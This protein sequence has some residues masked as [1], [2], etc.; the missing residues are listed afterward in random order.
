M[1]ISFLQDCIHYDSAPGLIK[2]ITV[3]HDAQGNFEGATTYFI[4]RVSVRN[5]EDITSADRQGDGA[6]QDGA[7]QDAASQQ[8][9][10]NQQD[11]TGKDSS[12]P[13]TPENGQGSVQSQKGTP[14]ESLVKRDR[15]G[16]MI[17]VSILQRYEAEGDNAG[18]ASDNTDLEVEVIEKSAQS[19]LSGK[20]A[21]VFWI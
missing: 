4:Q 8:D 14:K 10:Q 19:F 9:T 21:K 1:L 13:S 3:C 2:V 11:S 5:A 17:P 6:S 18:Q 12:Q 15:Y 7:S 16:R 20:F